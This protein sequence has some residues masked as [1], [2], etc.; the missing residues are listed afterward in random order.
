MEAYF[1]LAGCSFLFALE[2]SSERK[3]GLVAVGEEKRHLSTT[4]GSRF[5]LC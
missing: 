2:K 1:V 4:K 5:K 3:S